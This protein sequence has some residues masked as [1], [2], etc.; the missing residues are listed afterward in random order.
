MKPTSSWRTLLL[1]AAFPVLFSLTAA[2]QTAAPPSGLPPAIAYRGY[3]DQFL[4]FDVNIPALPARSLLRIYDAAGALLFEESL[5]AGNLNKR[6][7]VVPHLS[8]RLRFEVV[9]R[10]FSLRK[11]FDVALQVEEKLVVT[12]AL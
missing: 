12:A 10:G 1:A 3:A 7:K 5:G 8:H 2:G 11:S 9:G 4:Q 6:Y